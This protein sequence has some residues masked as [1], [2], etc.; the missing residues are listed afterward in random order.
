M[1]PPHQP[2]SLHCRRP[3][4]SERQR[5]WLKGNVWSCGHFFSFSCISNSREANNACG[6]G[7][8]GTSLWQTSVGGWRSL[9][10]R[11][12]RVLWKLK[13][14]S[15]EYLANWVTKHFGNT[16]TRYFI[17]RRTLGGEIPIRYVWLWEH[18]DH[19]FHHSLFIPNLQR[20]LTVR[21]SRA[22]VE[23]EEGAERWPIDGENCSAKI[24]FLKL[25]MMKIG[26]LQWRLRYLLFIPFSWKKPS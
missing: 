18:F 16:S 22:L 24:H 25:E 6:G 10:E 12:R 9:V 19:S 7:L 23:R 17:H 20:A 14:K 2:A 26:A 8:K 1:E 3:R 15:Y 5:G 13:P 21:E 4:R 11:R